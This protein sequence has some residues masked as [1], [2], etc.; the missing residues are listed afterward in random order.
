MNEAEVDHF[1]SEN[2]ALFHLVG[3]EVALSTPGVEL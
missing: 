1:L 2:F 3:R